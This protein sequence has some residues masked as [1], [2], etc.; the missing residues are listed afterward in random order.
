MAEGDEAGLPDQIIERER[1]Q[2]EDHAARDEIEPI[3]LA[4]EMGGE[5]KQSQRGEH[6]QRGAR[7][8]ALA[9]NSPVGR[10]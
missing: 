7:T 2:G 5:R 4:A 1:G 8:H 3:G 9:G 10:Q 6:D